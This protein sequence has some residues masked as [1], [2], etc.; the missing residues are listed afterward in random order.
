MIPVTRLDHCNASGVFLLH[1]E[2]SPTGRG[3]GL[4]HG[5]DLEYP[6]EA[7]CRVVRARCLRLVHGL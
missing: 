7:R 5:F 4:W 3:R 2:P 1:D 6:A